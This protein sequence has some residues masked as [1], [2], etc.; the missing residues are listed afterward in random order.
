MALRFDYGLLPP[1]IR[2]DCD[3]MLLVAGPHLI[4]LR[5]SVVP[6]PADGVLV[7]EFVVTAGQSFT[8]DV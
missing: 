2:R 3:T 8:F 5:G 7:A 1:R 4:A 6:Q